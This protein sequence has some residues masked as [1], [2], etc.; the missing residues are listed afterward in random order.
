MTNSYETFG[1]YYDEIV[2]DQSEF[3][4][5]LSLLI[6]KHCPKIK[7]VLEIAC[8]TGSILKALSKKYSVSGLDQS[9]L[10]LAQAA[11]KIP[12][13]SLYQS[14]MRSFDLGTQFELVVCI[15][16]SINHLGSLSDWKKT[17]RSVRQH[18]EA[19]GFFIFDINT[20]YR[21]EKLSQE[22]ASAHE[23]GES[24]YILDVQKKRKNSFEWNARLFT[25]VDGDLYSSIEGV[26]PESAYPTEKVLEALKP[27]F[28]VREVRDFERK[29]RSS[30]SE[31]L[32]FVCEAV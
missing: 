4:D 3:V 8:G 15:Y 1:L 13:A 9:E 14:D 24:V 10:M 25:P 16:D 19:G 11:Q 18:L 31:R 32:F 20:L 5:Q 29:R 22:E 21:L 27:Y 26:I 6:K 2:G 23:L 30:T 28:K 12:S 17:F 7:D